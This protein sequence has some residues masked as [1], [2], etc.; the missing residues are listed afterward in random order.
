NM[1]AR[2]FMDT[3]FHTLHPQQNIAEAFSAFQ[4]ASQI[5]GKKVFGMMV[6][7]EEDRLVG[8]LSMYDVLNYVQPKHVAIFG[9]MDDLDP[10]EA[11]RNRMSTIQSIRVDDIMTTD[12][13][14]V[15]PDTHL[16]V[17]A[18]IMIKKHIRRLP[19]VEDETVLGI[20]YVSNVFHRIMTMFKEK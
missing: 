18:E 16:M 13:V 9:E 17:I 2:D 14:T 12:V 3:R 5:E 11:Y 19:V 8:M 4:K 7:D 15:R 6:T 10:T 20:V 1:F